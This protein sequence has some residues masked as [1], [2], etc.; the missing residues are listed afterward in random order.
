MILTFLNI[1]LTCK[2]IFYIY[3]K[4]HH[5]NFVGRKRLMLGMKRLFIPSERIILKNNYLLFP[6]FYIWHAPSVHPR[7]DRHSKIILV[8]SKPLDLTN[9]LSERY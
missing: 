7:R 8:P 4:P 3:K 5:V 1:T 6:P 2:F 9:L